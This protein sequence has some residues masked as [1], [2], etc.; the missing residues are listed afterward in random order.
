MIVAP[1]DAA[2]GSGPAGR[3]R[4][5]YRL[6]GPLEAGPP[7][8]RAWRLCPMLT[9]CGYWRSIRGAASSPRHTPWRPSS[10][11]TLLH[12]S[13]YRCGGAGDH[14]LPLTKGLSGADGQGGLRNQ[15]C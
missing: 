15:W 12:R 4:E 2:E 8:G 14:V 3:V 13:A 7:G 5:V 6:P 11:G 9:V 10:W 1:F